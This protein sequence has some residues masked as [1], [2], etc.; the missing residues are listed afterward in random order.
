MPERYPRRAAEDAEAQALADEDALDQAVGAAHRLED[1]DLF[2]LLQHAHEVG[3]EDAERGDEDDAEEGDEDGDLLERH[4]R[5]QAAVELL[6]V[7]DQEV[8]AAQAG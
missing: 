1:R 6:P 7:L 2:G 3:A 5:E 8:T 4:R